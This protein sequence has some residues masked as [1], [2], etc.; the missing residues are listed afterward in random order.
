ML[1]DGGKGQLSA[2]Y[3]AIKELNLD[4]K[5]IVLGIAK[6]EEE[7]FF[8]GNSS[9]L[10]LNKNS[11]SLKTLQFMRDEAHRFGITHHRKKRNKL[12]KTSLLDQAPGIGPKLKEKL[13]LSF[14][15]LERIK[16]AD[17]IELEKVIGEKKA[18]LLKDFLKLD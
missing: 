3:S 15:T 9:P 12:T 11:T 8:A 5:M 13:Y 10:L 14:K 6:R 4:N 7:L 18:F 17:L 2:A 16:K 1:I